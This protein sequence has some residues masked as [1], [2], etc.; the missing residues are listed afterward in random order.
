MPRDE[1]EQLND[2][3]LAQLNRLSSH[4]NREHEEALESGK[5]DIAC[6]ECAKIFLAH[7]T[8]C[9]CPSSRF[10]CPLSMS[11]LEARRRIVDLSKPPYDSPDQFAFSLAS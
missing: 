4:E 11:Q 9:E 8:V 1:R 7:E 6:L 10:G 5:S 2:N 3:L